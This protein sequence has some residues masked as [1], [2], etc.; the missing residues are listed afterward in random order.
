[1]NLCRLFLL[2]S[3]MILLGFTSQAQQA[4]EV[5]Y[6]DK[7]WV[8]T[9][10]DKAYYSKSYFFAVDN[11]NEGKVITRS[12]EGRLISDIDFIDIKKL[13]KHGI[14]LY[15]DTLGQ[16]TAKEIYHHGKKHGP[17]ES[18][19]QNG[20]KRRYDLYEND[21]LISGQCF[22][23]T[24]ADTAYYVYLQMASFPGG[25]QKL[26]E[27]MAKNTKYPP[28]ARENSITGIVIIGFVVN[29]QGRLEQLKVE[30]SVDESL[31]MEAMRVVE[32]MQKKVIWS[33]GI[34]EGEKVNVQYNLPFRF[35]LR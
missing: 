23:T 10:P 25:D 2:S 5:R 20:Q 3:V 19:Y 29:T 11:Q 1:M 8:E 24:G 14:A 21:S 34:S 7:N 32:L 18:Y 17:L 28:Y 4:D 12:N 27:F 15:Y 9:G 30:K 13:E 22:S 26:L 33:A 35:S 6:F 16:L 31:D